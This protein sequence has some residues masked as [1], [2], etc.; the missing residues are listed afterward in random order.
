MKIL[1][2]LIGRKF[3]G[4]REGYQYLASSIITFDGPEKLAERLKAA[5]FS[6]VTYKGFLSNSVAIHKAVK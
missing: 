3:S 2:A 4:N 1:V 5:G 6:K